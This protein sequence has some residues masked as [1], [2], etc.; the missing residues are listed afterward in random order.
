KKKYYYISVPL[1]PEKMITVYDQEHFQGRRCEFTACCQ[2]IMEYGME[3]VRSLK[4]ECGVWVGFEHSTVNGQQFILEKG[5][6]PCW[7]AWSG[8]NAYRIERLMSFCPIYS[9]MHS[10]CRMTL[11]ECENMTGRQWEV[12]DDYPSLQAMG[13]CSNE[14]VRLPRMDFNHL[15]IFWVC[16]QYPGYRG[17]QYIM[18]CDCHG[19]EYRHYR[20][21]GCHA[22]TPQIQS[23]RRI[24][25]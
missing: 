20:E 18:E 13:W 14:I 16:Y 19:G 24:Q 15:I 1:T 8:S 9:A 21:Y 6:Y 10:D 3:T 17:Y 5:D 23:I 11:F 25:H 2:N 4:V 7:E 12:C 22:Q